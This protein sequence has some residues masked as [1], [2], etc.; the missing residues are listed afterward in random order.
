MRQHWGV[1]LW[2]SLDTFHVRLQTIKNT[3]QQWGMRPVVRLALVAG[4]AAAGQLALRHERITSGFVLL[5]IAALAFAVWTPSAPARTIAVPE[6]P[7]LATGFRRTLGIAALIVAGVML[8]L[9][10][11]SFLALPPG[12]IPGAL[13]WD[14]YAAGMA[15]L[16]FGGLT[17]TRGMPRTSVRWGTALAL[18]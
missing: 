18:A 5:G 6:A 9:A 7:R 4:L 16:V 3:A 14:R 1:P 2:R 15:F 17:L 8:G 13:P 10:A 12:E 11:E